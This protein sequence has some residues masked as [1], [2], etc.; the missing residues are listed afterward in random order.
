MFFGGGGER[1]GTPPLV[2]EEKKKKGK[3]KTFERKD[4]GGLF[5]L[6]EN[7]RRKKKKRKKKVRNHHAKKKKG[8][9]F[10]ARKEKERPVHSNA[11]QEMGE[12]DQNP[13]AF[14]EKN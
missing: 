11:L 8:S 10:L 13:P 5:S 1:G 6:G 4:A 2:L 7:P 9:V 14:L 12:R 3:A